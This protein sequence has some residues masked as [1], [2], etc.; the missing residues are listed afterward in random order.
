[1]SIEIIDSSLRARV[2]RAS[3]RPSAWSKPRR[4]RQAVSGSVRTMLA[5][6]V[7][8]RLY[9]RPTRVIASGFRSALRSYDLLK[10]P[11]SAF[12]SEE[13]TSELQSHHDLV[14]RL[15]LEKKNKN[16]LLCS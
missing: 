1:M 10:S 4:F 14:C 3:S 12:R 5:S 6:C 8:T 15:L 9:A 2:A 11:S 16:H 7:R 13:H